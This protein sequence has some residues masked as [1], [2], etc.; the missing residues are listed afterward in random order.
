VVER[1]S[2]GSEESTIVKQPLLAAPGNDTE[3]PRINRTRAAVHRC[4]LDLL[5]ESGTEGITH[6]ALAAATG[7]SRTTLYKHWPTRVELLIDI[8]NQIELRHSTAPTGDTRADLVAMINEVAA[9]LREPHIR[10]AFSALLA[11]AQSDPDALEVSKALTGDG[12]ADLATILDAAIAA[13]NVPSDIDPQEV[14][15]RLIG[16]VLF[17]A[18]VTHRETTTDDVEAVVDAW[19]ASVTP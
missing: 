6:A 16:P 10:R 17:A 7:M 19:L 1:Q 18:L 2:S 11:Q 4:G 14:A 5:F 9:S 3:D 15:G 13:G 12:L 8:C